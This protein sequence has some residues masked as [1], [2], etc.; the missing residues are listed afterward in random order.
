MTDL[1]QLPS[2]LGR[3]VASRPLTGGWICDVWWAALDDGR[4]VVVKRTPYAAE[5]EVDGLMALSR[6]GAPVPDVLG[7]DD[8]VLVLA[9]V[10]GPPD[11]EALGAR[12]AEVHRYAADVDRDARFGWHRDNLIGTVTQHNGPLAHWPTFFA[13][14][15]IRPLL[16]A[17]ALPDT[18]RRRLERALDGPLRELLD[19]D[20]FPSLVHGDLWSANVVDGAWLV[21]PAVHRADREFEIAYTE[22]WSGFPDAFASGYRRAWPLRPG[23]EHRRPAF[24]LYPLL[25][26]VELFGSSYVSSVEACLD[27]LGW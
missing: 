10:A 20:P 18:L 21:D 23:Y 22:L 7:V 1:P 15:R 12:L 3:V 24:Q 19:T 26:H 16:G 11:W 2:G 17:A 25:V 13:E 5:V 8:H 27:E 9:Y 14:R 4:E 6:A